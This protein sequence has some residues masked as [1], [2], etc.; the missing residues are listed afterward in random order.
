MRRRLDT[1]SIKYIAL[2]ERNTGA[3]VKDCIDQ[4][5]EIPEI[6][7]DW[8]EYFPIAGKNGE[9]YYL[10]KVNELVSSVITQKVR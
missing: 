3:H 1:E 5:S 7:S 9:T 2:F 6:L 4:A 8:K 10:M